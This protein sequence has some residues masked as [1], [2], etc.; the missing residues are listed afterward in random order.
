MTWLR[1]LFWVFL[2]LAA[3]YSLVWVAGLVVIRT[4]LDRIRSE[5]MSDLDALLAEEIDDNSTRFTFASRSVSGFPFGYTIALDQPAL[6]HTLV[7][8]EA[9]DTLRAHWFIFRPFTLDIDYSGSHDVSAVL[10]PPAQFSVEKGRARVRVQPLLEQ[11]DVRLAL[12]E[13]SGDNTSVSLS[14]RQVFLVDRFAFGLDM[15][16]EAEPGEL[17]LDVFGFSL[18]DDP[19]VLERYQ[20]FL[21]SLGS[22]ESTLSALGLGLDS[23]VDHVRLRTGIEPFFPLVGTKLVLRSFVSRGGNAMIDVLDVQQGNWRGRMSARVMFGPDGQLMAQVCP[24][25]QAGGSYLPIPF[26]SVI[27]LYFSADGVVMSRE[28][29]PDFALPKTVEPFSQRELCDVARTFVF[30]DEEV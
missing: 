27:V 10:Q 4:A 30:E 16:A 3:I 24:L 5:P 21:Q 25:L 7:S 14:D 1:R 11:R 2:F 18:S 19:V 6:E 28:P 15:A 22:A 12:V 13:A 29:I 17:L 26:M 20:E 9:T 8:W 23:P